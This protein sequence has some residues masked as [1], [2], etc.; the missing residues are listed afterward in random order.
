MLPLK[1]HLPIALVVAL[2]FRKKNLCVEE[3]NLC[4]LCVRACV[5]VYVEALFAMW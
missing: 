1:S 2:L 4:T 5:C 3:C